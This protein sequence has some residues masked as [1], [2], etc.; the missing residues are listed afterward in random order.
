MTGKV[1]KIDA[2]I[3]EQ[4]KI[5]LHKEREDHERVITAAG[6]GFELIYPFELDDEK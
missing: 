6:S 2:K 5:E 4:Q 3:K 1:V